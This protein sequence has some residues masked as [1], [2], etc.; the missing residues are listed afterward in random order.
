MNTLKELP[1]FTTEDEER[2]FWATHSLIDYID[3]T[4]IREVDPP[5]TPKT[6]DAYFLR[7]PHELSERI[8]SLSR[9]RHVPAE[10]LIEEIL[11]ASL[12][13]N[14]NGGIATYAG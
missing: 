9:E 13:G 6:R 5:M 12:H 14:A 10:R 11:L 1:D 8:D 3:F 2:E 7:L 4:K